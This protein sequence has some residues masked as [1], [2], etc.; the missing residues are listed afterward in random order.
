MFISHKI[1]AINLFS[2]IYVFLTKKFRQMAPGYV[3]LDGIV[4]L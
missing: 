2:V 1:P 3:A 4:I